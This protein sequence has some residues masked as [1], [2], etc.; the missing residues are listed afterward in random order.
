MRSQLASEIALRQEQNA[1]QEGGRGQDFI[2]ARDREVP[3]VLGNAR[4]GDASD[5]VADSGKSSADKGGHKLYQ[6]ERPEQGYHEGDPAQGRK[7]LPQG[8]VAPHGYSDTAGAGKVSG[9]RRNRTSL[10]DA[11]H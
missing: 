2:H 3:T 9:A 10:P 1:A 4:D 6:D 8:P 5:V 7:Q 11:L